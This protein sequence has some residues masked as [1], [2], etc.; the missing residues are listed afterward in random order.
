MTDGLTINSAG[1]NAALV[2]LLA[3]SKRSAV[4]VMKQQAKLLFAEVAKV[5][6]PNHDSTLGKSAERNAKQ[7]IGGDQRSLYGTPSLAFD[8]LKAQSEP[9][10]N[11]FW[12][13]YQEGD[14]QSAGAIVRS[15][16]GKSFTPFDGGKVGR[17]FLAKRRRSKREVIHYVTEPLALDAHIKDLQNHTWWLASGWAPALRALGAKTPYGV[18][19]VPAPGLLKVEAT[20]QRIV[21]TM[22]NEVRFARQVRDIQRRIDF[23]LKKRT[24][25]LQRT[26]DNYLA[27]M[28]RTSG[29]KK[30]TARRP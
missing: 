18:G 28:A 20:D 4:A 22:S 26:W 9:A 1:F 15:N 3:S 16:L 13:L 12:H 30:T 25:T 7:K 5:T 14:T 17:N 21:I 24:G 27:T 23:A 6:P 8:H 29:L 11:A 19:K 2:R 10:A